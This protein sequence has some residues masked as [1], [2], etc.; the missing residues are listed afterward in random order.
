M[1]CWPSDDAD[2]VPGSQLSARSPQDLT[3]KGEQPEGHVK[4][5]WVIG[6]IRIFFIDCFIFINCLVRCLQPGD[7]RYLPPDLKGTPLTSFGVLMTVVES[8]I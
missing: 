5:I 1:S 7:R 4:L 6:V 8:T 3:A 2:E